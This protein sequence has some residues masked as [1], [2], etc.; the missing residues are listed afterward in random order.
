MDLNLWS[1]QGFLKGLK[2]NGAGRHFL[3]LSNPI[4]AIN[5]K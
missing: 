5:W 3:G 1:F 2:K 4:F